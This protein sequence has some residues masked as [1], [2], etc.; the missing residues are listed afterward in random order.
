MPTTAPWRIT[1]IVH[2]H[3]TQYAV[4]RNISRGRLEYVCSA[5][6]RPSSFK[7]LAAA[8]HALRAAVAKE[9]GEVAQPA[10]VTAKAWQP[11]ASRGKWPSIGIAERV[12]HS[13]GKLYAWG[14]IPKMEAEGEGWIFEVQISTADPAK[15]QAL[16]KLVSVAVTN[17]PRFIDAMTYALQKLDS[18]AFLSEEGDTNIA[19]QSLREAIAIATGADD[20]GN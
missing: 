8:K 18:V 12:S 2:N 17:L 4:A 16:A 20:S 19:K 9:A 3:S 5:S 13:D 7:T 6:G 15:E 11:I 10:P 1:T 14:D